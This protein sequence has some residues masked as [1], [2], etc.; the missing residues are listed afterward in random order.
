MNLRD[1][2]APPRIT[3]FTDYGVSEVEKASILLQERPTIGKFR[4]IFTGLMDLELD[5]V[6]CDA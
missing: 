1:A 3:V 2:K 6:V 5:L 4:R